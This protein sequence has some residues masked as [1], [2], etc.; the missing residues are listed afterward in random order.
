MSMLTNKLVKIWLGGLVVL[1]L[2]VSYGIGRLVSIEEERERFVPIVEQKKTEIES[3]SFD[4]NQKEELIYDLNM[5]VG[6]LIE[7]TEV[8]NSRYT[9]LEGRVA[10]LFTQRE[11][12]F[13]LTVPSEG[14]V[15]SFAGTFGGNMYGM[16]H[17]GID[18]WTTI[19]NNGRIPGHKGNP[20]YAACEGVVNNMD[21][22]NAAI[23]IKCD[24]IPEH[25]HVPEHQVY[26]Y[27]AHLGS[28]GNQALF[29]HVSPSR[30]VEKGQLIGYQGDL[31]KFFPEMRNVHLHFS[32]F[33]GLSEVD[34]K[35]GAYNP[36][37]YIGGDCSRSGET[38][39]RH[40]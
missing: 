30:R 24:P 6:E 12:D 8:L 26:T 33:A 25:F 32:V 27:Y 14:V 7:N 17:L 36:C 31:S 11:Q 38:F 13:P 21:R 18:I 35:K 37:L 9:N 15:G 4:V 34:K 40:I 16:R 2:F 5:E 29:I 22:D 20:V 39:K 3:L 19:E 1:S 28:A 10:G 23:S